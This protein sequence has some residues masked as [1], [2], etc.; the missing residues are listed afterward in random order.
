MVTTDMPDR[1][2]KTNIGTFGLFFQGLGQEAPIAIFI[3]SVTGAAAYALGA[4]PL[5]FIIG[6]IASLL[7]GN[8]IYQ[9]SK[10]VAHAGGYSAYVNRGLGKAFAAFT[11]Y[12][13]VLY[14]LVGPAFIVL[15]YFWTFSSSLNAVF[16]TNISDLVGIAFVSVALL[17]AFVV[18][19]RGLRLSVVSLT[20]L[21]IIQFVIVFVISSILLVKAPVRS[22]QPF[23]PASALQGYH[24][25]FLGFITGS[26][27][28]YAGYGSVVPLGEEVKS[29][30]RSIGRAVLLII[31]IMGVTYIF[32]AYAMVSAWGMSNMANF[33]YSGFPGAILAGQFINLPSEGLI[34]VFYDAVIFTPLVTMLTACS[35]MMFSLSRQ[36]LLPKRLSRVHRKFGTPGNAV[37]LS[38][39]LITLIIVADA[40]IFWYQ[41]GFQ[42]GIFFS[43]IILEIIWSLSTLVIHVLVNSSLSVEAA[44]SFR[45]REILT[46]FVFPTA[47]SA[48]IVLAIA[49]SLQGMAM[50]IELAP[51]TLL[52][53]AVISIGVMLAQKA[54]VKVLKFEDAVEL[55]EVS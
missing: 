14:E 46:H 19:F 45:A 15:I 42:T 23:L 40:A 8:S 24:G 9:Y 25:L 53:Y 50:P 13:Y 20:V 47:A 39:I 32:S 49:Y 34:I 29:P 6:M 5:A 10:K 52:V 1:L 17:A 28:A 21:G 33:A 51:L 18:V 7:S 30:H 3:G 36:D 44:R 12:L 55:T 37:V 22:I 35:R 11:G 27:G 48:I 54:K 26:Y 41:Y 4:T 16:G 31:L 38:T 2:K 43:W